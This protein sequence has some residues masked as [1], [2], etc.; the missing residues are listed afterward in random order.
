[1]NQV[2]I[3]YETIADVILKMENMQKILRDNFHKINELLLNLPELQNSSEK[4]T[5]L[6]II[7]TSRR[8][9]QVFESGDSSIKTSVESREKSFANSHSNI[10][11]TESKDSSQ[12]DSSLS[13]NLKDS[14]PTP[15][16]IPQVAITIQTDNH[17][18]VP[19]Q[20]G[21]DSSK[22][23]LKKNPD[24]VIQL[25]NT[26]PA[27]HE[28]DIP[29]KEP[30]PDSK[31]KQPQTL[32][33]NKPESNVIQKTE[34]DD[35]TSKEA[36]VPK[37][38]PTTGIAVPKRQANLKSTA[39]KQDIPKTTK[40]VDKKFDWK[41][42]TIQQII[43]SKYFTESAMPSASGNTGSVG[44]LNESP[45]LLF[46]PHS[47][48]IQYWNSL[49]SILT[50]L[51]VIYLPLCLACPSTLGY[52]LYTLS[53]LS[54]ITL[55]MDSILKYRTGVFIGK[56]LET[57]PKKIFEHHIKNYS[58]SFD[59]LVI[60]PWVFIAD[61]VAAGSTFDSI[62]AVRLLSLINVLPF[63]ENLF[64]K[65]RV[66]YLSTTMTNYIRLHGINAA[67]IDS[68]MILIAMIFYWHWNACSVMILRKLKISEQVLFNTD[69]DEYSAA[70][71]SAAGEMLANGWG[72][73]LPGTNVDRWLT[74][75]NMIVSATF[76]ALFIGNISAFMIG[77]DSSGKRFNELIEEVN[78]YIKFKGFGDH[79]KDR[80][81]KYYQFKYSDGKYFDENRILMELNQPLKQY[82]A[83]RECQDLIVK[84]PFFKD[85]DKF[86]IAQVVMIL[87]VNYYLPGDYVIEE[88]TTGDQM[89]FI[90]SGQV[91]AI[92]NGVARAKLSPGSFFGEIALLFGRMKRTASI[93]AFTHCRLYSLSRKDLN[94]ILELNP[95]M[96]DRMKQ[97]ASERLAQD[98]KAKATKA[99]EEQEK[100]KILKE[101][102]AKS[103]A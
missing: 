74:V 20:L 94:S 66:A 42:I 54:T 93:R 91:E 97:V 100:Q 102:E 46:H 22:D 32:A 85:G 59:L 78:Q 9:L 79:L 43:K 25:S 98:E 50:T 34:Q 44:K 77:L 29:V 64:S 89:Y 75:F 4:E 10:Q 65:R 52:P 16:G 11:L 81:I 35:V 73:S 68:I 82:I 62:Y 23:V 21:G 38:N 28:K 63:V 26:A 99:K 39:E 7:E 61:A 72:A 88:G 103:K 37:P 76:L 17:D 3:H 24:T 51:I 58:I 18:P 96:A 13:K 70:V 27:G 53:I 84:V 15:I 95:S 57:D 5:L 6:Q 12:N 47:I 40:A 69:Y 71:F 55:L 80:I 45:G 87:K 90:A 33:A 92:V 30:S 86:F 83:L 8:K 56:H 48:A 60:I 101:L 19:L 1:M 36:A 67:L 49:Y 41:N 31:L 14:Q 2:I